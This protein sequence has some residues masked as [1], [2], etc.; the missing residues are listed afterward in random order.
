MK[1]EKLAYKASDL[2]KMEFQSD[3]SGVG[4][5]KIDF[6]PCEALLYK[7]PKGHIFSTH[8]HS[9]EV[10]SVILSGKMTFSDKTD[11]VAGT[12][13]TLHKCGL[14]RGYK[15]EALTQVLLLVMQKPGTK[16]IEVDA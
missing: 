6:G 15:G 8:V 9:D 7:I 12:P 2:K 1:L 11:S 16:L 13:G 4:I 14:P 5:A 3:R 10:I